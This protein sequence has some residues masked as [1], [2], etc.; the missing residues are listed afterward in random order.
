MTLHMV[1]SLQLTVCNQ[2]D[3]LIFRA[4][5]LGKTLLS[6]IGIRLPNMVRLHLKLVTT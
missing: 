1:S 6:E 5:G 4:F 2:H 3:L